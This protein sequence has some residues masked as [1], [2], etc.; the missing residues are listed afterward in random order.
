MTAR[1]PRTLL[2]LPALA[3]A[4]ALLAGCAPDAPPPATPEP[5]GVLEHATPT[6]RA[7]RGRPTPADAGDRRHAGEHRRRHVIRQHGRARGLLRSR[8]CTSRTRPPRG[9]GDVS[10][11]AAAHRQPLPRRPPRRPSGTS[12]SRPALIDNYRNNPGSAGAYVDDFPEGAHRRSVV[13]GQGDLVHHLRRPHH[14]DL[15]RQ[16]RVRADLRV[17][18]SAI[19]RSRRSAHGA[20]CRPP[21]AAAARRRRAR[22]RRAPGCRPPASARAVPR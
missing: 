17:G 9:E 2:V 10:D 7:D 6:A 11:H 1:H 18:R 21:P 14:A 4:G 15:H 12:T 8:R 3:L 16:H 20:R 19:R 5:V 22:S 13:R